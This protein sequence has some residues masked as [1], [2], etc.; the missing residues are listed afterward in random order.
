MSAYL[1]VREGFRHMASAGGRDVDF[2]CCQRRSSTQNASPAEKILGSGRFEELQASSCTGRDG[3][4]NV[5]VLS[6]HPA[7]TH[8]SKTEPGA[9]P[10]P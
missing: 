3:R 10:L 2:A 4:M 5:A 6:R 1:V 8:P 9:V 7:D